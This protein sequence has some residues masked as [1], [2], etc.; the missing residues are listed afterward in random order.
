MSCGPEIS[1]LTL[2]GNILKI[3]CSDARYITLESHGRFAR[4][5][6]ADDGACIRGAEFDLTPFFEKA[7]TPSMYIHLTVTAADGTYAA[8][9]AHFLEELVSAE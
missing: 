8:T 4:R 3:T 7:D 6:D 2:D 9:R 1:S 5:I